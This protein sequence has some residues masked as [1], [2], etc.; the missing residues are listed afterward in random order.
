MMHTLQK[1]SPANNNAQKFVIPGAKIHLSI[2]TKQQNFPIEDFDLN[3][4]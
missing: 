4:T 1:M 2:D 3:N